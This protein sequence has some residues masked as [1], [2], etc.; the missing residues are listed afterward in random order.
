MHRG[1]KIGRRLRKLDTNALNINPTSVTDLAALGFC[2]AE[3]DEFMKAEAAFVTRISTATVDSC[4]SAV[5]TQQTRF[6][7]IARSV[8]CLSRDAILMPLEQYESIS[9]ATRILRQEISMH[10]CCP[11]RKISRDLTKQ[12]GERIFSTAYDKLNKEEKAAKPS[13]QQTHYSRLAHSI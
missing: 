7:E 8:F 6:D 13:P 11:G 3:D 5:R 2:Y 12:A 4:Q 10:L 9:L 1:E